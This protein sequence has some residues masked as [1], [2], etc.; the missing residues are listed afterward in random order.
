MNYRHTT[1]HQRRIEKEQQQDA[2][3]AVFL[4]FALFLAFIYQL[5]RFAHLLDR[6]LFI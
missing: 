5:N 4:A 6:T 1:P 2:M 3:L